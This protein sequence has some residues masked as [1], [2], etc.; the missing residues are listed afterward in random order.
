MDG[1]LGFWGRSAASTRER[2]KA[3]LFGCACCGAGGAG[4]CARVC[5]GGE[6]GRGCTVDGS[7]EGEGGVG[8]DDCR[9]EEEVD[10]V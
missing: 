1:C 8:E 9:C 2:R 5:A 10:Y 6:V 3:S 7:C 4:A